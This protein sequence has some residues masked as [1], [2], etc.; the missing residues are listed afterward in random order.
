MEYPIRE[1]VQE[2]YEK[3]K[4]LHKEVHDLHASARPDKYKPAE[5]TLDK[6][7]FSELLTSPDAKIYIIEQ[8]DII[9]AFTILKKT[10]PPKWN[11]KVQ[12]P[13]V[14]MADLGVAASCR[15]KGF[16]RKLFEKAVEFTKECNAESLELGV[17]EFNQSAIEFYEEM[18][19]TTQSR[20]MEFKVR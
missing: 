6:S 9:A 19:M 11:I 2:D 18:G 15:R 7:Y 8:D 3:L 12:S 13:V 10:W 14:F 16:A 1:A 5:E 20:K 4:P 17:W